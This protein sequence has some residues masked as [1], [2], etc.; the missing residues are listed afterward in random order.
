MS[1]FTVYG[2][3]FSA[4]IL[5]AKYSIVFP[6]AYRALQ[7]TGRTIPELVPNIAGDISKAGTPRV[8][9]TTLVGDSGQEG[10]PLHN[11]VIQA[12]ILFSSLQ[13]NS[14]R[15]VVLMILKGTRYRVTENMFGAASGNCEL[16]SGRLHRSS[17]SPLSIFCWDW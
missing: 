5:W 11:N 13:A 14:P 4:Q 2:S 7:E 3:W 17:L 1:G 8:E 10:Q 15:L 9:E 16:P 6:G 12:P